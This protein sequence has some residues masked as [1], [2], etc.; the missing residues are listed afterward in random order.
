VD[1]V[2]HVMPEVVAKVRKL[3]GTLGRG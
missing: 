3:A 1:R 2:T